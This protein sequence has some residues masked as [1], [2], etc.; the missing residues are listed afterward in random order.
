MVQ[1]FP[2]VAARLSQVVRDTDMVLHPHR[3]KRG[4]AG[5]KRRG[6]YSPGTQGHIPAPS[7]DTDSGSNPSFGERQ[8][9]PTSGTS[10]RNPAHSWKRCCAPKFT[11]KLSHQNTPKQ[12]Q[13]Y[14]KEG[15]AMLSFGVFG[16]RCCIFGVRLVCRFWCASN[17]PKVSFGHLA[18]HQ[19]R[20]RSFWCALTPRS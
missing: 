9:E 16:G 3:S 15:C 14:T 13:N 11:P 20:H 6:P 1:H 7:P 2:R 18:Q 19:K 4:Q 10:T 8:V 5:T 12:H 17:T